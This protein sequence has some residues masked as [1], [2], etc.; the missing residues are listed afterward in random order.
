MGRAAFALHPQTM[1]AADGTTRTRYSYTLNPESGV[2]RQWCGQ[3]KTTGCPTRA[4]AEQFVR[5]RIAELRR[6]PPPATPP[7]ECSHLLQDPD[8]WRAAAEERGYLFFR[9]GLPAAAVLEVRRDV[10]GVL[11]R[12]C[13]VIHEPGD[14]WPY[15]LLY[16]DSMDVNHEHWGIFA[17]HS[18]DGIHFEPLGNVLPKWDDR[19]VAVSARWTASTGSTGAAPSS[20]AWSAPACGRAAWRF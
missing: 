1:A 4:A 6:R 19:F 3:R 7:V 9:D 5:Q 13:A 10:A 20:R 12:D 18:R 11:R 14:E 15:K 16:W 2:P 17:T 8:R